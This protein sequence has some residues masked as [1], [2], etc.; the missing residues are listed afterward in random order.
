MSDEI[1]S[2][3]LTTTEIY[4]LARA[5]GLVVKPPSE[6]D[7]METEYTIVEKD[8]GIEILDPDEDETPRKYAH[9]AYNNDYPE[10]GT[11]PLGPELPPPQHSRR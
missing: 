3:T 10:E 2:I 11:Y 4:D 5:A 1:K 8:G 9:G 6:N 7:P